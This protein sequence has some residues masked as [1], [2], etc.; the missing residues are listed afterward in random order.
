MPKIKT[1]SFWAW[2]VWI[3]GLSGGWMV[4]NLPANEE[5]QV[6]SLSREGPLE[7]DSSI[8]AWEVPETEEPPGRQC[9]VSAEMD[10][11]WQLNNNKREPWAETASHTGR[12]CRAPPS[13]LEM[14]S[15]AFSP[16]PPYP[17]APSTAQGPGSSFEV[18]NW[19]FW[20]TAECR[21]RVWWKHSL[22]F[23]FLQR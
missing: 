6:W 14:D 1:H 20:G 18:Q 9:M 15:A 22:F 2:A 7:K 12:G 11:T 21:V 13:R 16:L 5:M 23:F 17:P 10:T 19:G 8:L 3:L 4:Q